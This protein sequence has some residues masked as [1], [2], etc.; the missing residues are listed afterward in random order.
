[1]A[2]RDDLNNGLSSVDFA[3]C[4]MPFAL[5]IPM[6]TIKYIVQKPIPNAQ[7]LLA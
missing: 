2:H 4:P 1:M 3:L 7:Y 6:Y 5:C